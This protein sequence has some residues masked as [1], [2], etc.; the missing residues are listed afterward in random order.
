[1]SEI[2]RS[3]PELGRTRGRDTQSR[4]RSHSPG[5]RTGSTT[6]Q[7]ISSSR[8]PSSSARHR[9]LPALGVPQ[10]IADPPDEP[11][12]LLPEN[13]EETDAVPLPLA[14]HCARSPAA[15]RPAAASARPGSA[16]PRG[17]P[18]ARRSRPGRRAQACE[19]RAARSRAASGLD[20]YLLALR[21]VED[22]EE[23][24]QVRR[25]AGL[26]R[27]RR[28]RR[29]QRGDRAHPRRGRRTSPGPVAK[30]RSASSAAP[31]STWTVPSSSCTV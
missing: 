7:P 24:L 8:S 5:P 11:L 14:E 15:P 16:S 28:R 23:A 13:A 2:I 20:G 9:V 21:E 19:G 27:S 18:R 22:R 26:D 31:T 25:L 30:S 1:M 12:V 3:L 17:R 10:E 6:V 4:P 29:A